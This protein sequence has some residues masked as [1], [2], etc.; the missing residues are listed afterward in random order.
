MKEAFLEPAHP[1]YPTTTWG[2][3]SLAWGDRTHIMGILN[4]TP[5]SFSRDGLLLEQLTEAEVVRLAVERAER[6]VAVGA[7]LID[8]GGEST[9]PSTTGSEPLSAEVER[10]RVVPVIA[11]LA[12]TLPA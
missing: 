10:A 1:R 5:D 8:V 3:H 7:E 4:I 2:R 6:M 11:A 12:A 9:R